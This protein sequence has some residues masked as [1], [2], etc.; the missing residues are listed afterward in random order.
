MTRTFIDFHVLQTVPPSNLNRDDTGSPKSAVYGGVRRA[1]VSSQAWKRAARKAFETELDRGELGVRTR[2][3]VELLADEITSLREDLREQAIDLATETFKAV[4]IVTK[5][6]KKGEP[7]EAG[8]LVFLSRS[9]LRALAEAAIAAADAGDVAKA[10]KDANVKDLADR[11]HSVDIALF[12]RMVA[13]EANLNVDAAAQVA[14]AISVHA[15]ETEFD[16][17]TAVDDVVAAADESGAGMIGTVEFN[18]ATLYRYATVDVD[19]L[20]D[21]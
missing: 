18:S 13:D 1:R 16:Y 14:H 2:R 19:R 11:D 21:N 8:Y 10:L 9:Q 20:H 7:G 4:G 6:A 5:A 17:F 12:G 15:A 3:I